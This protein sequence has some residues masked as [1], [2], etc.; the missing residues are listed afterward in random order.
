[1]ASQEQRKAETRQRLLDAAALLFAERGIEAVSIDTVA[2]AADRTSGAVYAH[3]GGKDGVLLASLRLK[4]ITA[5][6]G[7][8]LSFRDAVVALSA[9]QLA[10]SVFFQLAGLGITVA[11]GLPYFRTH[12]PT[13]WERLQPVDVRAK[14]PA[15]L[16]A[17]LADLWTNVDRLHG[18]HVAHGT[19]NAR[20]VLV[21]G[22]TTML[23]NFVDATPGAPPGRCSADVAELLVSTAALV[24]NDRAIAAAKTAL[25]TDGIAAAIP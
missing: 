7:Y 23:V 15:L 4:M 13:Q 12:V 8:S 18:V 21:D 20:H 24:G 14:S 19:L 10:G 2:E 25:G 11:W 22:D 5:D 9:G 16:D 3:F 6:L 1:M 17:V